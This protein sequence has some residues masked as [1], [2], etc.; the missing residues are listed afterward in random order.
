MGWWRRTVDWLR[1]DWEP[2]EVEHRQESYPLRLDDGT[3]AEW[4][5]WGPGAAGMAVSQ[6]G[7]LG[8]SSVFR[9]VSLISPPSGR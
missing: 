8:L 3:F 2:T 4:M 9:C 1:E 5:G 6:Q 7:S